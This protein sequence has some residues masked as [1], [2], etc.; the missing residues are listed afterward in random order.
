MFVTPS[1]PLPYTLTI[2][3]AANA[4]ECADVLAATGAAAWL[5]LLPSPSAAEYPREYLE[6]RGVSTRAVTVVAPHGLTLEVAQSVLAAVKE[7]PPGPLVVQCATGNRASAVLAL[8][9]GEAQ[10]WE[11]S[12]VL[13]WAAQEKLPFL[14]SQALC[15]W[16]TLALRALRSGDGADA[17]GGGTAAAPAPALAAHS[18]SSFILRHLCY[19]DSYH[20]TNLGDS[21]RGEAVLSE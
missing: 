15:N 13:Q 14:G 12:A 3:G 5:N 4:S 1:S 7:L 18:S 19:R 17:G 6:A 11:P 2:G 16:V 10:G 21:A 8:L 9:V 20:F